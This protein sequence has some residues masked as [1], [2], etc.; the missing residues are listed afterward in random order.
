MPA[1]VKSLILMTILLH[2][3]CCCFLRQKDKE[4]LQMNSY[5]VLFGVTLHVEQQ[6][7]LILHNDNQSNRRRIGQI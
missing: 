6:H 4:I 7:E 2:N 1:N 5:I 3:F